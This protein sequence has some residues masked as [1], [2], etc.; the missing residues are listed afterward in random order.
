MFEKEYQEKLTTPQEAVSKI[1]EN[2]LLAHGNLQ[3]EPPALLKAIENRIR[4]NDLKKLRV[5]HLGTS[6]YASGTILSPELADCVEAYPCFVLTK[7]R[8]LVYGGLSQF[9]PNY[10][11]Q[12]RRLIEEY[13]DEMDVAMTT[14]S[15]MDKAGFFLSAHRWILRPLSGSGPNAASLRSTGICPAFSETRWCTSRMWI[16]SSKTTSRSGNLRPRN[17]MTSTGP[18]AELSLKWSRMKQ[19]S[20]SASGIFPTRSR[21]SSSITKIWAFIPKPSR[22][23]WWIW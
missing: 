3:A 8:G 19:P 21:R 7:E 1:A 17:R 22:P 18:S 12:L 10:F 14:V 2:A 9:I 6:V 13:M 5:F 23:S 16:K 11:H 4:T 20:S 15:P